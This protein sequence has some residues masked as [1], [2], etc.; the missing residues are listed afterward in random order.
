MEV[1]NIIVNGVLASGLA[2][3]MLFYRSKRRKHNAEAEVGEFNA[4]VL[5]INH[6]SRQLKEAYAEMDGMQDIIERKRGELL[7][8]SRKLAEM[9]MQLVRAEERI[10]MAEYNMCTVRECTKRIPPRKTE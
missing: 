8:M 2:G 6:F 10:S 4:A 1:I 7:E 5:Q 3:M 9:R